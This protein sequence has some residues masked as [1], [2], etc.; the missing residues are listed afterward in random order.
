MISDPDFWKHRKVLVTG[1]SGFLGSFVVE[2]LRALGCEDVAAPRKSEFDLVDREATRSLYERHAPR[3]VLHLAASVGGIGAN[4]KYPG[5]FFYENLMMGLNLVEEGRRAG[6]EKFV[7]VGTVCSYPRDTPVP[8][9]EEGLWDGY[10]EAT[11]APYGIAKKAILVQLQAYREQYGMNG[12][13][14]IPVNLFG[15]RDNFDLESSHVIPALIRKCVE[16]RE[17]GRTH[18]TVWGTG[19]ASREFFYV[20]DCA[21]A[22][23]LAAEHYD[24]PEPINLGTGEEIRIR[25]LA[26]TI[27]AEVG[28]Q[29]ELVFD[30]SKPDGQPR[31]CL[32][33][34]RSQQELGF[35]AT[36]PF[37][38]GLRRT[39][40][41]FEANRTNPDGKSGPE[42]G[43]PA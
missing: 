39:I 11:N 2:K 17:Q 10:P 20:E 14:V 27:A 16:A 36:T 35:R 6:V 21:D 30:P 32:D 25:H 15:P 38:E 41:W 33:V 12:V 4:Q 42:P 13:Y 28:F 18:V 37:Q 31:R 29:G 7:Q 5:R 23:L 34:S 26:R 3:T 1:G 43:R 22:L 8:F 40:A 9:R 19:E 24:R